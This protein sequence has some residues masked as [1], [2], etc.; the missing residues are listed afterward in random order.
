MSK[1]GRL[2][3]EYYFAVLILLLHL[4]SVQGKSLIKEWFQKMRFLA[5][6]DFLLQKNSNT[7]TNGGL[8]LRNYKFR[9]MQTHPQLTVLRHGCSTSTN[10]SAQ[11][12]I[13]YSSQNL[14]R[15][16]KA[17]RQPQQILLQS[18]CSIIMISEQTLKQTLLPH[19]VELETINGTNRIII[20]SMKLSI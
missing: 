16:F 1:R 5:T 4:N 10:H 13:Q 6:S 20:I 8:K 2:F 7:K 9:R 17:G 11:K 15:N 3:R 18:S 12:L 19:F 14:M